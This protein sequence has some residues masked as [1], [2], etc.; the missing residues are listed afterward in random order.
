VSICVFGDRADDAFVCVDAIKR[1]RTAW[2]GAANR[3]CFDA[4][5]AITNFEEPALPAW[6]EEAFGVSGVD[7]EIRAI[8]PCVDV[9][10]AGALG[11]EAEGASG[12]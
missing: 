1:L 11:D 10:V 9:C 2:N 8:A 3:S 5:A 4:D 7:H 12:E 6:L